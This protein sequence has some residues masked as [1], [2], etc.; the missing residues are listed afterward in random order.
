MMGAV[1]T[2]CACSLIAVSA[3][4]AATISPLATGLTVVASPAR[5][6]A[7]DVRLTL[8][9][10]YPMQCGYPGAGP[11]VVT[12]PAA[13]VVPAAVPQGSVLLDGKP[14]AATVAGSRVTV[15][16]ASH[17]GPIC[18][19]I[20]PGTVRLTIKSQAGFGNPPKTA[21]YR[22][23]AMHARRSFSAVLAIT[24]A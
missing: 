8:T 5:A 13:E 18:D 19:V 1:F 4:S 21:K 20:G 2:A 17:Q 14:T 12:L 6:G 24:S 10:R 9:L 22:V 15:M 3:A 16:I 7:H 11:L 23:T